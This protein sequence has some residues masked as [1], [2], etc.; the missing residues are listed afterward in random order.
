MRAVMAECVWSQSASVSC[1]LQR[2][3]AEQLSFF[4]V[5]VYWS[6][7]YRVPRCMRHMFF[8]YR[9]IRL[10]Y[11]HFRKKLVPCFSHS[12]LLAKK[13][14]PIPTRE[15]GEGGADVR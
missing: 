7:A 2:S 3:T 15:L 12:S 11:V 4:L 13:R 5:C 14:C 6:K 1:C 8:G 9:R 10:F